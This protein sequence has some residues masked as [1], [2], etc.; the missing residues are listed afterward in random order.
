MFDTHSLFACAI[1]APFR[2][3]ELHCLQHSRYSG[4]HQ[5]AEFVAG[6]DAPV[7][8]CIYYCSTYDAKAQKFS[9]EMGRAAIGRHLLPQ[10]FQRRKAGVCDYSLENNVTSCCFDCMWC[11]TRK[12][13]LKCG[14]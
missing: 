14:T 13:G 9:L 2:L 12:R 3:R 8:P 7:N 10:P 4:W 11:G 1:S 5:N 6:E